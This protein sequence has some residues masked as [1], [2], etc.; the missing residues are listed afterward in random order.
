M[1]KLIKPLFI[2][3]FVAFATNSSASQLVCHLDDLKDGIA[4]HQTMSASLTQDNHASTLISFTGK[5]GIK[6]EVN[7]CT[8][9]ILFQNVS[10]LPFI[11]IVFYYDKLSVNSSSISTDASGIF[12]LDPNTYSNANCD[13]NEDHSVNANN[14]E[15]PVK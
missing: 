5:S 11:N 8:D 3:S 2:Q 14:N 10:N 15:I 13:I 1:K 9:C 7:A 6:V 12:R 4:T